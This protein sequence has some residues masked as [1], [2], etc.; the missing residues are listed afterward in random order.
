[1][2]LLNPKDVAENLEG[3]QAGMILSPKCSGSMILRKPLAL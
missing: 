3:G 1:M 2:D